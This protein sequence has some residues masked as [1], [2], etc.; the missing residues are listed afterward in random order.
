VEGRRID[1]SAAGAGR[2]QRLAWVPVLA[3]LLAAGVA[4]ASGRVA[5]GAH[6]ARRPVKV[7]A[8]GDSTAGVVGGGLQLWAEESGR[9]EVEIVGDGGCALLQEGLAVLRDSWTQPPS[10]GCTI[11]VDYIVQTV[12]RSAPDVIVLFLGSA[13]L[14]DWLLPGQDQPSAIGQP[15]FDERYVASATAA[16]RTLGALGVPILFLTTPVPSWRPAIQTGNPSTPGEG[17]IKMNDTARTRRLNQLTAEVVAGQPSVEMVGWAE[18]LGGA[19]GPVDDAIRPDGL[20]VRPQLV[21]G[22][23]EAGLE[24]EMAAAYQ[25]VT[26]RTAAPD[27]SGVHAWSGTERPRS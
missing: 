24:A 14:S 3:L 26:A 13:Q 12:A 8:A 17:P 11:L 4:L 9:A 10:Y 27:R 23:M 5:D 7:L 20:H 2:L 22:I 16:L 25:R 1:L 19:D 21:P 6:P 18:R 15:A